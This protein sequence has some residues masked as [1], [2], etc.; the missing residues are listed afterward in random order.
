MAYCARN[1]F[2]VSGFDVD[3][4]M[5][6]LMG[7]VGAAIH[8]NDRLSV[9]LYAGPSFVFFIGN[10]K[11]GSVASDTGFGMGIA[12]NLSYAFSNPGFVLSLGVW[13]DCGLILTNTKPIAFGVSLSA[14]FTYRYDNAAGAS[15]SNQYFINR[16]LW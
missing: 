5:M 4:F 8:A 14:E 11:E 16:V 3:G 9:T 2:A 12:G 1:V 6:S 13:G 10:G 15:G 7:G